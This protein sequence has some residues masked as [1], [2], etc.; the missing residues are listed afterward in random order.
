M[1][2]TPSAAPYSQ[3]CE[4]NKGPILN[5]L[6]E[7]FAD[8]TA[9]LEIGSGTGQHAVHFAKT[10]TQLEWQTGDLPVNHAGI[11]AWLAAEP[12]SN[13]KPPVTIDLNEPQW[14]GEYDAAYSPTIFSMFCTSGQLTI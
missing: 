14:P 1:T 9:V 6:K 2:N 7:T 10:L 3:A 8:C 5:I 12:S 11:N 4:N 13:L